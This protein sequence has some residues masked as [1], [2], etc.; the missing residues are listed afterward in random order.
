MLLKDKFRFIPYLIIAFLTSLAITT[1]FN[2]V[3]SGVV[4]EVGYTWSTNFDSPPDIV[5]NYA[6]WVAWKNK[7][8]AQFE[9]L[10][11]SE[12]TY[13]YYFSRTLGNDSNACT[14]TMPCQTIAKC[15]TLITA[16]GGNTRCRFNRGEEWN[17]TTGLTLSTNN[18]TIDA[19]GSGDY[20]LFND[21]TVKYLDASNP[22]TL[23]AGNRYTVAEANDI[24]WVRISTDRLGEIRRTALARASSSADCETRANSFF[25]TASTLH[26]NLN[27]DNPNNFN[28]EAVISNT[29][30]GVTTTGTG[31]RVENIRADGWGTHRTT[32][33]PQQ[34][35]FLNNGCTTTANYWKNI[36]GFYS[37]SHIIAH[38]CSGG[39]GG[40]LMING[41][42]GGFPKYNG[43]SGDNIF[44]SYSR[45]GDQETWFLNVEG[46]Y[47]TLKSSDWS[48]STLFQRGQGVYAHTLNSSFDPDLIVTDGLLITNSH[49]P[50]QTFGNFASVTVPSTA[51]D[52][53]QYR[54]FGVNIDQP[55]TGN[56]LTTP[57]LEWGA[58][59]ILYGLRFKQKISTAG[60]GAYTNYYPDNTWIINS[61]MELDQSATGNNFAALY[62][63]LTADNKLHLLHT[64]I[65]V[66]GA[67]V[68]AGTSW[69]L[70]Y[71]NIFGTTTVAGT[72]T[73]RNSTMRN[74]ILSIVNSGSSVFMRLSLTNR[75]VGLF[76]NR[77]FDVDQNAGFDA[78]YDLGV[79]QN[80]I[81]SAYTLNSQANLLQAGDTTI[82]ASHDING[83]RRTVATPDI[84]PVDFSSP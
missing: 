22:W 35:P 31:N 65:R 8:I 61:D 18:N 29:N 21:F 57:S 32:L 11:P 34:H 48:Y 30:S 17:E 52:F 14:I 64:S 46:R 74:S 27:G 69:G 58:N 78:G 56:A 33:A 23:A 39:A 72:G 70:D 44:N 71:D 3:G 79:N 10:A 20:P 28:I 7:R 75:A 5:R 9:A 51:T 82:M 84:G 25:W 15:Q 76:G 2:A 80:T 53:S 77:F 73:S 45:D 1:S 81:G 40:H 16:N 59:S 36:E 49:S 24:A 26:I 13:N 67:A 47:G 83:K 42:V 63:T 60:V 4:S 62:N 43:G 37:G 38:N 19:Y 54:V 12:R 50:L 66:I 6:G 68:N 55:A 41:A